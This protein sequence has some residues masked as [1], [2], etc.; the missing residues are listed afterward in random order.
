MSIIISD[1]FGN[2]VTVSY[3]GIST[4]AKAGYY[5]LKAYGTRASY[6]R[7]D[8][9]TVETGGTPAEVYVQNLSID[10]D[11]AL[12]S[13]RAIVA[14]RYPGAPFR[15]VVDFDLDEIERRNREQ[16]AAERAAEE[17]RKAATDWDVFQFG[18][19]RGQRISEVIH[20]DRSYVEW[21][22]TTSNDAQSNAAAALRLL[23]PERDAAAAS[24]ADRIAA[25][26]AA[27]EI[28][29]NVQVTVTH[30]KF[31]YGFRRLDVPYT[32]SGY[33]SV[34]AAK[35]LRSGNLLSVYELDGAIDEVL[36][37][38]GHSSRGK[39]NAAAREARSAELFALLRPFAAQ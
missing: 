22:A 21:I 26:A 2:N 24:A 13:A 33:W 35:A 37:S 34:I 30:E 8:Y 10:K 11:K 23:Q 31:G 4:G 12:A 18:K 39:K 27:V 19:Y 28:L 29:A 14:Q 20:T 16:V 36:K 1:A 7:T 3:F 5:T 9:G 32:K 15:G 25:S 38:E 17:V 6:L